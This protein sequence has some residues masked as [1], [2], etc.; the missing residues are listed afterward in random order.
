MQVIFLTVLHAVRVQHIKTHNLGYSEF[1]GKL[2]RV[3][4]G[5]M[6]ALIL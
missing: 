1:G 6:K 2:N 5:P 4:F 3:S